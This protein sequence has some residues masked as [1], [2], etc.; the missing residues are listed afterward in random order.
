MSTTQTTSSQTTEW[1]PNEI[2]SASFLGRRVRVLG[3]VQ[4]GREGAIIKVNRRTIRVAL[5]ILPGGPTDF[6]ETMI[7]HP[8]FFAVLA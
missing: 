5:D 1:A 2:P 3:G 8:Q 4:D 7:G 6:A